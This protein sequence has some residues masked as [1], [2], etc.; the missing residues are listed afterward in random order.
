MRDGGAT[1]RVVFGE[2]QAT[3]EA[4]AASPRPELQSFARSLGS[5]LKAWAAATEWLGSNAQNGYS[6]VLTA[7]VPY[8]HL[9]VTVTGGWFMGQ[10][11]LAAARHLDAGTGDSAFYRRKIATACFYADQLLPQARAYGETVQAGDRALAGVEDV[12]A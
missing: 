10:A 12:L 11:A 6:A 5:A 2:I 1:A 9:A 7:A 4:L 3:A 8:L